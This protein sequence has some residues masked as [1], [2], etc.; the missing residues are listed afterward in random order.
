MSGRYQ[1]AMVYS[2]K[3]GVTNAAV[4]TPAASY[5]G[6][7]LAEILATLEAI[8]GA[9]IIPMGA[10]GVE[11]SAHR[12]TLGCDFV[13]SDG[14][15]AQE[16]VFGVRSMGLGGSLAGVMLEHL[17]LATWTVGATDRAGGR[18]STKLARAV[19]VTSSGR[20]EALS[21]GSVVPKPYPATGN[22]AKGGGVSVGIIDTGD[23]V[24][25]LRLSSRGS[26]TSSHPMHARWK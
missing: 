2:S 17:C 4:A 21:G 14:Q 12:L 19:A 22:V 24:A 7:T 26:A 6:N 23:Y 5:S 15:T 3:V 1:E 8:D 13:G 25:I 20:L 16:D 10:P 11:G 18:A 9:S